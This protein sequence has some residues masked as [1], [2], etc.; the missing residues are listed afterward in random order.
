MAEPMTPSLFG[1]RSPGSKGSSNGSQADRQDMGCI[2]TSQVVGARAQQSS[3]I[4]VSSQPLSTARRNPPPRI[5]DRA[6]PRD[7]WCGAVRTV[8]LPYRP[9]RPVQQSQD[10]PTMPL[11]SMPL[12]T[13]APEAPV[14]RQPR[15]LQLIPYRGF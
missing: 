5:G 12:L 13:H 15:S 9:T 3:P 6:R 10:L 11:G 8:P 2:K 4:A 14:P 7:C 1:W